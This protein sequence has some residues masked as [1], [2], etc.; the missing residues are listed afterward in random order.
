MRFKKQLYRTDRGRQLGTEGAGCVHPD[1]VKILHK[2]FSPDPEAVQYAYRVV[3]VFED[4]IQKKTASVNLDGKMV[5]W[6]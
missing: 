4:G 3:A 5:E 2:V 6:A 1:Q